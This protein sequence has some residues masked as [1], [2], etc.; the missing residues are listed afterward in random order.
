MS[1]SARPVACPWPARSPAAGLGGMASK[2][3]CLRAAHR[4]TDGAMPEPRLLCFGSNPRLLPPEN[5]AWPRRRSLVRHCQP[6]CH[7]CHV[8]A[9]LLEMDCLCIKQR[10]MVLFFLYLIFEFS[11]IFLFFPFQQS[12]CNRRKALLQCGIGAGQPDFRT[13]LVG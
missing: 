10:F 7:N 9:E 4:L 11:L 6:C 3:G 1:I 12:G 2:A 5:G 13:S 8:A